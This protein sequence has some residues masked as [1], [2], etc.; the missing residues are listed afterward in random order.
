MFAFHFPAV[1]LSV[2][3]F[4]QPTQFSTFLW[5]LESLAH[6]KATISLLFF[7][8]LQQAARKEQHGKDGKLGDMMG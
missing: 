3:L 1:P 8:S 2:Y 6:L 5:N 7:L 4:A